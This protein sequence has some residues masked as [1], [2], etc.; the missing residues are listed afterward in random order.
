MSNKALRCVLCRSSDVESFRFPFPIFR[1][2]NLLPERESIAVVHRCLNCQMLFAD[3]FGKEHEIRDYYH[4]AEYAAAR[5]WTACTIVKDNEPPVTPYFLVADIIGHLLKN[6]R[7]RILDIGCYDGKLLLELDRRFDSPELHGFD[8]SEH[9]GAQF[10]RKRNFRYW[11][12]SVTEIEGEFDL[13]VMMNSLMYVDDTPNLMK[14]IFGLLNDS[15]IVLVVVPDVS[16]NK[17]GLLLGDEFT[18]FT[19]NILGNFFC[20]YGYELDII[21]SKGAFPRHV[22]GVS[23]KKTATAHGLPSYRED[24]RV[25][26]A[27]IYLIGLKWK[28][29]ILKVRPKGGSEAGRLAVLG[30]RLNAAVVSWALG[31]RI[32]LFVDENPLVEGWSFH[33]KPVHHPR[34]LSRADTVVIPFGETSKPIGERFER[35]Y[36]AKVICV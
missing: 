36:R 5:P 30:I 33:G 22:I 14:K 16:K 21:D 25:Y 4:S 27:L 2:V 3:H 28:L 12:G 35:D 19:P 6:K 32:D 34:T 15:G 10:T 7:P 26:D 29:E 24:R 23:R 13:V 9:L 8:V 1:Y 31:D 20:H 18:Y 17:M 11:C